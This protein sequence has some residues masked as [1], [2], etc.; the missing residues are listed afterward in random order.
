MTVLIVKRKKQ[1][2]AVNYTEESTGTAHIYD[3][4]IDNTALKKTDSESKVYQ[5]LDVNK[6]EEHQY[7]TLK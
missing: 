3:K 4:V 7:A 2:L 1:S 5:E 6:I